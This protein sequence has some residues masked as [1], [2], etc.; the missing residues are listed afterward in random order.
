MFNQHFQFK[1]RRRS[2]SHNDNVVEGIYRPLEKRL[3]DGK[4]T[5]TAHF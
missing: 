2:A 1:N 4:S 3:A 5:R